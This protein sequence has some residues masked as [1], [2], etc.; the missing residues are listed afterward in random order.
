MIPVR[1]AG[2]GSL[3]PGRAVSTAEL[4][5]LLRP[6]RSREEVEA[7]TG[8]VSRHRADPGT[9]AAELGAE[10]LRRALTAARMPAD[11]LTRIIFVDSLGGDML[12]PATSNGGAAALGLAGTCACWD[13]NNACMGFLS[14]VDIGARTV[15]TGGGPVGI[16]VVELGSRYVTPDEPRPF[17]VLGDGVAAAVLE[18]GRGQEGILASCLRNDPTLDTGVRLAHASLTG[19]REYIRFGISNA[20]LSEMAI[21]A[22]CRSVDTVLSEAGL[23]L[24]D[25]EWI[26][27]HQPN[28]TMLKEIVRA[29]ALDPDRVVPVVHEVGSV[30][31]ASIPIA[32]D[33]LLRSRPVRAGDRVLMVGVGAGLSTGATIVRLGT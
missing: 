12:I 32:L 17:L 7:R 22:V 29:L 23:H 33:R 27:P 2:T 28:G 30:G 14:A 1:I 25:I 6:P 18:A 13:L 3:S 15:A 24:P 4:A 8:I 19:G 11:E 5:A 9:S 31:A 26:L 10:A 20:R 21:A 16:V